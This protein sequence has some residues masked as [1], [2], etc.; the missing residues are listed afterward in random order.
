MKFKIM[1]LNAENLFLFM[2]KYDG[3][4]IEKMDEYDWQLMSTSMFANKRLQ[5]LI[6]LAN[7]I[8]KQQPDVVMLTEIGGMESLQNFCR[9]FLGNEYQPMLLEGNSDRG[10]DLGYL[11]KRSLSYQLQLSSH[12]RT[13]LMFR[14]PHEKKP[15]T[16]KNS[17]RFSRDVLEL[18]LSKDQQ[19]W[20]VFLLVHLKSKL[21]MKRI[22]F[23]GRLR[24]KAECEALCRIYQSKQQQFPQAAIFIGGDFNG[25][26]WR[27]ETE[28]EFH[29]LYQTDLDDV[30]E[31]TQKPLNE[32]FTHFYFSRDGRKCTMQ[33]D[34]LFTSGHLKKMLISEETLVPHYVDL[35]GIPMDYPE[36]I[37]E[38]L[39]LPSDHFPLLAT[40]DLAQHPLSVRK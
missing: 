33:L 35:H 22:D 16:V 37:K 7:C 17:L 11:V 23:E 24:R 28:K 1:V 29:S 18:Q 31:L 26:A 6:I 20:F 27:F 34:Y 14:Y 3:T 15:V 5:D 19:V 25:Q 13:P 30:L 9:H 21:D 40:L 39:S 10:I 32:R 38:K 12:K 4:P 2:D 36:N 8:Q